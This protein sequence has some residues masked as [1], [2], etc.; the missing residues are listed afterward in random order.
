M[1]LMLYA[2]CAFCRSPLAGEDMIIPI[3]VPHDGCPNDC[4]FCNQRTISG[5]AAAP[6]EEEV[7]RIIRAHLAQNGAEAEQIA[8]FGG[9]FTGIEENRRR[10]YL[11]TAYEYVKK[12]VV[13]SIRIS[14]RPDYIN[15][16]IIKE[17]LCYKVKN[18]EL[19]AQS[20]DEAVLIASKRGH[21]AEDV[22]KAARIINDSGITLGLQMMTGLPCDSDEKCLYTARRFKELGAKETRIYPTVVLK[23]TLLSKMYESGEYT[24]HSV[25]DATRICAKLYRY[26]N[27]NEIKILRIGLPDSSEL[28][29]NYI[30]GAY[31]PSLGEMVISRDIRNM[32]EEYAIGK[33]TV[34]LRVN[35]R[36]ISKLNGN[37]RCNIRYFGEKGITLNVTVD[38]NTE[39]IIMEES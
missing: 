11:E 8:F 36:F 13:K 29:E 28:R 32:I 33:D 18:V 39:K 5:K 4:A 21:S 15:D 34:N 25:E 37:K 22:E 2:V 20:M 31:H 27:D 7:H 16:E 23:G 17:L 26:F 19:G 10:M 9:S 1:V 30:A 3:F 12:G 24:A 14:T 6:T 35:S 38:E